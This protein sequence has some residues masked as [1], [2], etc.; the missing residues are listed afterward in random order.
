MEDIFGIP[1][2]WFVLLVLNSFLTFILLLMNLSNRSKI[3][4]LK[5]RYNKFMSGLSSDKNMEEL[6][7]YYIEQVNKVASKNR[8]IEL[9]I[10]SLERNLL[11]CIQKIGVV[12]F[13]AFD[14]VGS[15]LSFSVALL[16]SN[17]NGVILSG[18]YAR[19]SSSTYAKPV[20][21][22]KSRYPL[23]AEELKAINI[24]RK[25]FNEIKYLGEYDISTWII[26]KISILY[27]KLWIS[28]FLNKIKETCVC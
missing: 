7:D 18:I 22:G 20:V 1:T 13:N 6:L 25:S 21:N 12:R 26:G 23:S 3:K 2:V 19:D 11:S 9:H 16:D 8:E 17:D 10:N 28:K 5:L 24:A 4:K 27:I 14:D 15:D